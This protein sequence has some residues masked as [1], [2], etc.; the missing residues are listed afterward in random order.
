MATYHF[1]NLP[2]HTMENGIKISPK[3]H[4]QYITRTGEYSNLKI[5]EEDD[6]KAS[7]YSSGNMPYWATDNKN[8]S[9]SKFWEEA[10][11]Y[12]TKNG[13][14]YREIEVA[15]MEEFNLKTN[16]Q[17][18]ETFLER[19][20]IKKYHA[21]SYA[22]HDKS[23]SFEKD[24]KN[25][26]AHIMFNEKIIEHD[27]PLPAEK[28]FRNYSINNENK[29]IG[30]YK[31]SEYFNSKKSMF[32]LRKLWEVINNEE[33][34]RQN[35]PQRISCRTLKQQ[36]QEARINGDFLKAVAVDRNSAPKLDSRLMGKNNKERINHLI[37]MIEEAEE[38]QTKQ[39]NLDEMIASTLHDTDFQ[40]M[41]ALAYDVVQRRKNKK[42]QQK[43]SVRLK[44]I[45]KQSE[46]EQDRGR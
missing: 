34:E 44:P 15:L 20:G 22:I 24:T 3:K 5:R 10:E 8:I 6:K 32:E 38:D 23:A 27:R 12:K 36:N 33:F 25:I 7:Y 14:S 31:A 45:K 16:I 35:L 17:I 43:V 40:D 11:N 37:K 18:I 4:Y 46:Q 19:S 28:Y 13:R 9:P 29:A 21:Y 26:H 42:L 39:K 2:H 30:G 1:S 41:V